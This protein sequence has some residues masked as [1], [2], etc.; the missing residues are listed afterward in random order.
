MFRPTKQTTYSIPTRRQES[1]AYA[2]PRL[3]SSKAVSP[4]KKQRLV[5]SAAPRNP[6]H[7]VV[8]TERKASDNQDA[9]MGQTEYDAGDFHDITMSSVD[10]PSQD[11]EIEKDMGEKAN[12]MNKELSR[13]ELASQL[14]ADSVLS[15]CT[16]FYQ[17]GEDF[18]VVQG[19]DAVRH[20]A[21]V[22]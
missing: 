11:D 8:L 7:N 1:V 19:W 22:R 4:I 6:G 9:T 2:I 12:A 13:T 18:C 14:F 15:D 10:E 3:S 17:I 21:T 5:K 16:G 20:V